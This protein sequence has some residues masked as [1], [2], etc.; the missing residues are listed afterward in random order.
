MHWVLH[1]RMH[2][3]HAWTAAGT[4][5]SSIPSL[6]SVACPQHGPLCV[7][8]ALQIVLNTGR[9]A[10]DA[11]DVLS[12]LYDEL[13]V[14][15]MP[16]LADWLAFCWLVSPNTL[17][18]LWLSTPD[19]LMACE[20]HSLHCC[21]L[22]ACLYWVVLKSAWDYRMVVAKWHSD[23]QARSCHVPHLHTPATCPSRFNDQFC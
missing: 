19:R 16:A 6:F 17:G 21:P 10:G 5:A 23:V 22:L 2:F 20:G 18:C 3:M 9:D 14:R 15:V 1:A 7:P 13:L 8:A 4:P 12:A 11:R